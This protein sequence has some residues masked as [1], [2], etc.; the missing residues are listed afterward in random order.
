MTG[1]GLR[2]GAGTREAGWVAFWRRKTTD[3]IDL[4]DTAGVAGTAAGPART[5]EHVDGAFGSADITVTERQ[6]DV[7]LVEVKLTPTREYAAELEFLDN[8]ERL[9]QGHPET[10]RA[11]HLWAVALGRLPD[12]RGDAVDLLTW[13]VD[14]AGAEPERRLLALNDLTRLLQDEGGFVRAEQRLREALSGWERLR[15]QD[16]EQTLGIASNL[17]L[18]LLHLDRHDE[19]EGLMRDTVARRTRTLGPAHPSTLS[20]RNTLA[21]ALRGSPERLA[22]AEREYRSILAEDPDPASETSLSALHNLAAVLT[23]HGRHA[24]ALDMYRELIEVRARRQGEDHPS[25]W[26]ARHNYAAVLTKLGQTARAEELLTEVVEARRRLCGPRHTSTLGAQVDLAA[27]KAN[28]GRAAEAVPLL[29]EA[30]EGYRDT[31]G[32]DHPRVRQLTGILRQLGG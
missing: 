4:T 26:T 2:F 13:L 24:E 11:L 7:P 22:E 17:A 1:K 29:R 9:G 30:I 8:R 3:P 21:G 6:G 10:L 19:A 14:S 32:P 12:R 16:D 28:Q 31:H 25:T 5:S 15:G 18:V 20:S 23:H 27:A